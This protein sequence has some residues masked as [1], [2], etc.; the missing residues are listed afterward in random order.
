MHRYGQK[1]QANWYGFGAVDAAAAVDMP[2]VGE[3]RPAED[4]AE[5]A[6]SPKK[7]ATTEEESPAKPPPK[8]KAK[9]Q[10][11]YEDYTRYRALITTHLRSRATLDGVPGLKRIAVVDWYLISHADEVG[12]ETAAH[13]KLLKQILKRLQKD[14]LV[15]VVAHEDNEPVLA[16]HPNV[17]VADASAA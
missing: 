11:S 8:K 16:V 2:S 7:P 3:K 17:D 10:L 12:E 15:I 5:G 9:V 4:D 6:P 1:V 13:A 14:D